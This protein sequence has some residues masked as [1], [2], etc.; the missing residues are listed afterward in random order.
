[1]SFQIGLTYN[2]DVYPVVLLGNNFKNVKVLA[3]MDRDSANTIG[4]TQAMHVNVYPYLPS[5]TPNNPAS[6][7]WIKVRLASGQISVLGVPW[8]NPESIVQVESRTAKVTIED[9][10]ADDLQGIRNALVTNGYTN[11]KVELV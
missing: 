4:D 2:F 7:N 9:I 5:G 1:M 3:I 6:Y 8:I 10:S 11:I